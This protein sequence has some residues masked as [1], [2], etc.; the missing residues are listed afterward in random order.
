MS[1]ELTEDDIRTARA[2]E[3]DAK[4]RRKAAVAEAEAPLPRPKADAPIRLTLRDVRVRRLVLAP[5]PLP[6]PPKPPP[7]PRDIPRTFRWATLDAAAPAGADPKFPAAWARLVAHARTLLDARE[8]VF[9]GG[10][11]TGKTSIATAMLRA[12]ATERTRWM[13]ARALDACRIQHGAGEGEAPEIRRAVNADLLLLD[14]LGEYSRPAVETVVCDRFDAGRPTWI[15]TW[16]TWAQISK[17][18]GDGVARRL[19]ARAV[20][21]DCGK[22][23][24]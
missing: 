6:E 18:Y 17:L 14:D 4:K 11:G 13:A 9:A 1:D 12:R 22:V 16:L 19:F 10:S 5:E 21:F 8:I 3:A 23:G 15:T 7:E 2:A 20:V 24:R